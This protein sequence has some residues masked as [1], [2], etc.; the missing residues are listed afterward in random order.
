M[1]LT[2]Q[3]NSRL[4]GGQPHSTVDLSRRKEHTVDSRA[5]LASLDKRW[6]SYPLQVMNPWPSKTVPLHFALAQPNSA[7]ILWQL[8][9]FS[10]SSW[11]TNCRSSTQE[12][13]QLVLVHTRVHNIPPYVWIITTPSTPISLRSLSIQP[14]CLSV[15][16][17]DVS[18]AECAC[19]FLRLYYCYTLFPCFHYKLTAEVLHLCTL[20]KQHS[21]SDNICNCNGDVYTPLFV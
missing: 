13:L 14:P 20:N 7:V 1:L 9:T 18:G 11:R 3:G 2:V 8:T 17:F 6:I 15:S 21:L 19:C 16:Q 10:N 4:G 5:G 12:V